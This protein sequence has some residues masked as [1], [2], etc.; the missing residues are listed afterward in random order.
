MSVEWTS[1]GRRVDVE[2]ASSERLASQRA[3]RPSQFVPRRLPG[4]LLFRLVRERAAVEHDKGDHARLDEQFD[5]P[6]TVVG[7]LL[8]GDAL[9]ELPRAGV[10]ATMQEH[11]CVHGHRLAPERADRHS[12]R[13]GPEV[14]QEARDAHRRVWVTG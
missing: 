14:R 8:R 2:W 6:D 7:T 13:D 1:S 11:V 10:G 5:P 4:R 3:R 12:L 9:D